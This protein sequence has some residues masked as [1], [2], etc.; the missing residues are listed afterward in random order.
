ML[1]WQDF[2]SPKPPLMPGESRATGLVVQHVT[3][4]AFDVDSRTV[5]ASASVSFSQNPTKGVSAVASDYPQPLYCDNG[6]IFGIDLATSNVFTGP[7]QF[8]D[9]GRQFSEH[10]LRAI[11]DVQA[12]G[13][14]QPDS[15]FAPGAGRL[16]LAALHAIGDPRMYPFDEYLV[17]F[18]VWCPVLVMASDGK[19]VGVLPR[20]EVESSAPGIFLR[21]ALPR[22]LETWGQSGASEPGT[23]SPVSFD[24]GMWDGR[25]GAVILQRS[26]FLRGTTVI[27]GV[28]SIVYLIWLLRSPKPTKLVPDILGFFVT[29]WG[30]REILSVGAPK[31]PTLVDH[32]AMILYLGFISVMLTKFAMNSSAGSKASRP[33]S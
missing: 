14:C 32:G 5:V 20:N 1:L 25:Q 22:E 23:A 18:R 4:E 31:T 19:Y 10:G 17:I 12:L 16:G 8:G 7:L 26:L 9:L 24:E 3:L 33:Q 30:I 21:P 15:T 29:V 28:V 6:D 13:P 27:L 11:Q 2:R